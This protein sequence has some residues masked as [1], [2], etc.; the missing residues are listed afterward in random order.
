MWSKGWRNGESARLQPMC[1]GFKSRRRRHMWVE[2]VVG[3]LLCSERFF[4]GYS[5]FPISTKTNISEFQ[6]GQE[7]GRRRTTLWM[8]YLQIIIIIIVIIIII[9]IIIYCYLVT[10]CS[11]NSKEKLENAMNYSGTMCNLLKHR[12]WLELIQWIE[13]LEL[14]SAKKCFIFCENSVRPSS[15]TFVYLFSLL[16]PQKVDRK[17]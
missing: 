7:L 14:L 10:Q 12:L 17:K 3:S 16:V 5:A 1:P 4:S 15:E 13:L 8:C 9:I 6:F 11:P 2:F